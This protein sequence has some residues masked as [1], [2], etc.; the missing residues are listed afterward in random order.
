[1]GKHRNPEL[2]QYGEMLKEALA[3]SRIEEAWED[4]QVRSVADWLN[5]AANAKMLGA[6]DLQKQCVEKARAWMK[7]SKTIDSIQESISNP[8]PEIAPRIRKVISKS[9][10]ILKS[11]CLVLCDK[12][13]SE[14][15][16]VDYFCAA[17]DDPRLRVTLDKYNGSLTAGLKAKMLEIEIDT[18]NLDSGRIQRIA[19]QL[20]HL[21]KF[22][23]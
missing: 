9:K 23:Q 7:R 14:P 5:A 13:I 2:E 12:D 8:G 3:E 20:V 22:N 6:R 21:K 17:S 15:E 4:K 16:V 18:S 19:A 10:D 11:L 1:M